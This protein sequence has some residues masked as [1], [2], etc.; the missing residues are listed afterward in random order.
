MRRVTAYTFIF[1]LILAV[2]GIM[3]AYS[4]K[5]EYY[6]PQLNPKSD[7][8]RTDSVRRD[9]IPPYRPSLK[10]T[11]KP[12]D[13]FG[14]PFSNYTSP[15]PLLLKDPASLLLDLEIDTGNNYT[16]YEKIGEVT[17]RPTSFMTFEEFNRYQ[18]EKLEKDYWKERSTG[19]DGESAV[20]GRRL[21]PLLYTS[22]VMDRIFGGSYVDIQTNGFV[23]LDFGGR[24]QKVAN[25]SIPVRQ[26]R[27]GGFNYNQQISMN[28]VG[29]VGEK[30]AITA[31]FD[32]NNSFDFQNKLKVDYT[33]YDEDII[34]KIEIG[35]VS[36]PVTNSLISGG[37]ALFGVK[38]QMQFGKLFVT[39]IVSRQQG[40]SEVINVESGFQGREFDIRASNYDENRHFFLGHFF[41]DNYERWLSSLPQV[42]SGLNITR[43]EVYSLNRNNDTQTLRNL[44]ALM[45]LGEG[46]RIHRPTNENI[47][48]GNG[49]PND[50]AANLLFNAL[51]NDPT[52]R[53]ID[54]VSDHL[55]RS[56]GL[57]RSIDFERVTSARKL[58][59]REFFVNRQLGY[60]TMLRKLQND[61]VLAVAYEYTYNGRRYKVG[62]LM[63][64]Y[65][66]LPET[67]AIILKMLRPTRIN[68]RVPTWDLM[69]KNIYNLNATQVDPK[70][71]MLRI[72]YRDDLTGIDNPSLH[73]GALT[74]DQPLIRLLGLDQLNPNNDPAPDGNFDFIDGVT[75]DTRNGNI[76]FPVLEPF[77]RTLRRFFDPVTEQNFINKYVYDTLYRTTKADA[78]LVASRNKFFIVGRFMA[79]SASEIALPGI[80]ISENSVRVTAGSTP[81]TEGLD[82]TVDYNLGRVRIINQGILNSGKQIQ[83]A[84]EKA[85]LFNFQTRWLTGAHFDYRLS[86]DVNFGATIMHL[87]E[88]PGGVSRFKVGDEPTRN[89]KYGL[90]LSVRKESRLLTKM[91]DALPFV[92]TKETSSVNF[93]GEFA[94]LIPGTSNL[95][96]GE[97][98]SYIDDF[99][100]AIIPINLGNGPFSWQLS[101]TPAT[102]D[103]RF[104]LSSQT[105]GNL[106]YT[107]KRA[108]LSWYI[109]DPVFYLNSSINKPP[110]I[111]SQDVQNHY[112]RA[113]SPQEVFRQQDR[114]LVNTNLPVFDIAYYPNERGQYNY[115]TDLT[116]E[117]FLRNPTSNYAGIT[118]AL[119]N[120]VDFDKTNVEYLEFWMMDPF[121]QGD[122]GRV[123]DGVFN[124]NN[125]TG[126]ELIFNLGDVSED[127]MKDG[128]H[129]FENGLPADY[130][131][132]KT[133]L[134]E[135]GRTTTQ[136]YLNNFFDNNPTSRANQDVGLDGLK[137]EDEASYF[138]DVFVSKVSVNSTALNVIRQDASAD[139]F[140]HYL[141]PSLVSRD[142]KVQERYKNYNGMEGNT[143]IAAGNN[144][145]S[146]QG[147]PFPENED[148]NKDNTISELENYYEYRLRLRPGDLQVG[149]HHIV[150]KITDQSGEATWYLFRI[151]IRNPDRIQ[152]SID[153][154]KS[155]RFVRTYLTG[156][157]QPVVLRMVKFQLVGSQWRKYLE[158]LNQKGFN[159]VP[160]SYTSDFNLSVVNIE[161]NSA[162]ASGKTRYVIPPGINRDFDNTTVIQRRLNEQ[163]LQIC[164]DDLADRDARAVFKNVNLDMINYGRIK[165]FFHAEAAKNDF[166]RDDEVTA[167]LRLGTDFSENYYEI[168]VPL[169]ITPENLSGSDNDI[170]RLVWP[171]E[172][173]IDLDINELFAIKT[174]RERERGNQLLPYSGKSANGQYKLTV[175]GRPDISAILAL[176]IGVR[177]PASDDR[178]SKSVCVWANEL[179]LT[180]FNTERGWAANAR[181]STKLADLAT[182][183][184]STRYT[185]FGFGGIQQRI[186]ERTREERF[187]YDIS[188]NVNLDKFLPSSLGLRV[189]MFVSYE[190]ARVTPRFDPLDPDIPLEA[191]LIAFETDEARA[192]YRALVENRSERRSLNFSNVRKERMNPDSRKDIWDIENFAFNYSYSDVTTTNVNTDLYLLQQ[193]RGGVAY[194]FT[195][196]EKPI[197]PFKNMEALDGK[198]FKLIKDLNINLLP[199][200]ISV[201]S[202]LDRRFV[203]TQLRNSDLTTTGID[204][205]YEKYFAFNRNYN[206]RWNLFKSLNLDYSAMAIAVVDEPEGDIDTQA[207]RD[208]IWNNLRNLGRMRNYNQTMAANYRVPLDKLPI[209]DWLGADVR[210]S[211]GYNW[212]A[213]SVAQADTLGHMATNNRERGVNG[214]IDLVALYNKVPFLKEINTPARQQS[215]RGANAGPT[216]K[217][218]SIALKQSQ[219]K[220][221]KGFVRMLMAVRSVNFTYSIREG[222]ILPGFLPSP[223]L[224]GMDQ[225]FFA[226]GWDF[227][228]GSQD[229]DIR[230]R[231]A[232]NGWMARSAFLTTPFSQ[233]LMEDL[234]IRSNVE[235]FRDLKIQLDARRTSSASFQELFRFDPDSLNDF[236]SLTPTR[237]GSYSI[238]YLTFKTAFTKDLNQEDYENPVFNNFI[239][240]REVIRNRLNQINST[241]EYQLNSQ[242]VIVPAF[243]AAYSGKEPDEIPLTPFPRTPLPNWRVDYAGLGNIPAL[244]DIFSAVNLTHAYQSSFNVGNYT[245][246]LLYESQL[247]LRNRITDYPMA[248]QV[249]ENGLVP[250]YIINQVSIAERFSP[251]IGINVR[252]KNRMTAKIDY[253][254]ERNLSLNLA[255]SQVTEMSSS[256]VSFDMGFTKDKFKLPFKVQGK[257]VTLENDLQF[258]LGFTVRDTKTLQRRID[259]A[260]AIT[261]GNIN[262]QLRPTITYSL[263]QKVNLTMYFDRNI[264]EPR[265]TNAFRRS[266]TAFGAQLRFSLAQ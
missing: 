249:T 82:Y 34:K 96:N 90:N 14:D 192:K 193:Y 80:N 130:D 121:I 15:S 12:Y 254:R 21:I 202:D 119:T 245:N 39:G 60:I 153:G 191:S 182:I 205:F 214:K 26:Q 221:G 212:V 53:S 173:E 77:G 132:A 84:Y 209:T 83:I 206:M 266:T 58:D 255:N 73:E 79:G 126:G 50:N 76:I 170:A 150:D 207:K 20:S 176:M 71:F 251:L 3:L 124:Q 65:Q 115:N 41:R 222:T 236:A 40:R 49:G 172:N 7:S 134:N 240:Y 235:P 164:V 151:P 224:L 238:S 264:N 108:K 203:K 157:S 141:D 104:D 262:F 67:D 91:V 160:E 113:I 211:V 137:S 183:T 256:D 61:E 54:Q 102:P 57:E 10:P 42:I 63:E 175:L 213:G 92:S 72:Q 46:S 250:V 257:T 16:I 248:S 154:F 28:V 237:S 195:P 31:N 81:L 210:Y 139:N 55:T 94:Q 218:D 13:R 95:I 227:I 33:G 9:T 149:K 23:N 208:S 169:K 8:I 88:R 228:T 27:N 135:W 171:L 120:E 187:Q 197:E 166:V 99:E 87:N 215:T 111:S 101:S 59:E 89:T 220:T 263:N 22:P 131:P 112:V 226:P 133:A 186:S 163:S 180:D 43:I 146:P 125:T 242:D 148:L 29:K 85:D 78:E 233:T 136:Q 161:E 44:V 19:L 103:N 37:Q 51:R 117:G 1:N 204:P 147:N 159:E 258:R 199:S 36:M 129:A 152:G 260:N 189:P 247:D 114:Q 162:D 232:E 105:P 98:T 241:G 223:S 158:S 107:Y 244:K 48:R 100:T 217:L 11:F 86:E 231:A 35:N 97:Q 229:A 74:K 194:N 252:T 122:R 75:M 140:T 200:N 24:W 66:N 18:T 177:N 168:E 261:N 190:N 116:S 225:G 184:A 145:F 93:N 201:R 188:A 174:R 110:N 259:D 128:R 181:L 5:G 234:N 45:D 64:D 118:K 68:T 62:E 230:F 25:P 4:A 165:M 70:G 216:K 179:R 143:P 32:N 106:G 178:A 144:A 2:S 56:Y 52:V 198:Y 246:S 142:A 6:L 155:I 38:T 156:W 185:S 123:L 30:L 109:V 127:I 167:F 17:Y 265:L 196:K 239:A 47:G 219:G 69:M 253:K 243:L 138:N